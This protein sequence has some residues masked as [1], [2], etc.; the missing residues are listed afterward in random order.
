MEGQMKAARGK[1][2]VNKVDI[3]NSL[4]TISF[5]ARALAS[6]LLHLRNDV[7]SGDEPLVKVIIIPIEKRKAMKG[8]SED[9][10]F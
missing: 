3:Y 10:L 5:L 1:P 6:D 8:G 2:Q 9:G 4:L 7:V